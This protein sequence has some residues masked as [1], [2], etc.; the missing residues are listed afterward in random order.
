MLSG[1]LLGRAG[2]PRRE[3]E[4]HGADQRA[5]VREVF[6]HTLA[7]QGKESSAGRDRLGR[8]AWGDHHRGRAAPGSPVE[9]VSLRPEDVVIVEMD[10]EIEGI[11]I[12]GARNPKS[13]PK[14]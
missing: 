10:P 13:K 7:S 8:R 6:R 14:K 2:Q 12:T 4:F 11:I 3:G 1:A 9:G 5:G